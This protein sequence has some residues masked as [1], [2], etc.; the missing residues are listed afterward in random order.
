MDKRNLIAAL[1]IGGTKILAGLI[2]ARSGKLLARRRIETQAEC[3]AEDIV[4]RSA[5]VLREL[6]QEVDIAV[7][8]LT[9]L[10]CSIPGPLDRERGVVLFS[11]HL[12]W[13]AVPLVEMFQRHLGIPIVIEDDARCAAL[14]EASMGAARGAETALY[15]TVSTGI[16]AGVIIGGKIYRGAHGFAGEVGHMTIEAAGPPC[17]CG[18][19]GCFEALASGSAI[20]LRARQAVLHGDK[21]VLA[22][23]SAGRPSSLKAEH[24]VQAAEAGDLVATRIIETAGMYLGIGLAAM[25][26]AYDPEVIVLGGGAAGSDGLLLR[27]AREEFRARAIAPLGLL[28]RIIPAALGDESGLWGAAA[29][30]GHISPGRYEI[31]V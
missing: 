30:F 13:R 9:G 5:A 7:E 12:N 24:V 28:V 15:V 2:D 10:G 31:N 21:T 25:A 6:A 4:A 17:A 1:D 18:N 22:E 16:G 27:R 29:L 19:F 23:R 3:G 20:A 26:S 8:E 14:G 11:P